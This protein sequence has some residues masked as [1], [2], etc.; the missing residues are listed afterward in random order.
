M[1]VHTLS[2][3]RKKNG[4]VVPFEESKI[5][6]A[7]QKAINEMD[8]P[9]SPIYI[10]APKI[11]SKMVCDNILLR[12]D[13]K[14]PDVNLV[15]E[16]VENSMMDLKLYDA[17][18]AYFRYRE[19]NKKDIFKKRVSIKPYEYPELLVYIDAIRH[20][21]WIHSEFNYN[22]DIQDMKVNLKKS[23]VNLVLRA[24][25]AI[26]QIESAVK[27]FWGRV[28]D[29][30]QKPEVKKVGA[31]FAESEVRHEDAYSHLIE[32]LGLNSEFEKLKDVPAIQKRIEYLEKV[33][34]NN[35]AIDNKDYF[36][37]IILF[38]MFIENV[39]L[40]SQFLI[41]MSFN[42]HETQLKGMSNAVEA[43]SKEENIHAMF[44]FDL[45]NIIKKEHPEWW[46]D[47]LK[48]HIYLITRQAFEAEVEVVE[49]MYEDA[50]SDVAP[51]HNTIEYIKKR[52][53]MSL[54]EIGLEPIFELDEDILKDTMW[55]DEEIEINKDIDFFNKRST[56][57]TKKV[58]SV[59]AA[60]LF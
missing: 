25:L 29:K 30:L 52:L 20:S 55:F 59:S 21:Y 7:V 16:L 2:K 10:D 9:Q 32:I 8:D 22:P 19:D 50:D 44:G 58:K 51:K 15:H 37:S 49:W 6:S 57:Y 34:Q 46:T 12:E 13:I 18:R 40:F 26:S 54:V 1:I 38:S 41:I 27:E 47:S 23:D 33:N 39:S 45:V 43:T 36:E 5:E 3:I 56:G 11:V 60:D 42:K 53:N 14:I 35:N 24:M 4:E 31:T 48:E 17:A 28:G